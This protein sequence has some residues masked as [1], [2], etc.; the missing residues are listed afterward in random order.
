LAAP[1]GTYSLGA[2]YQIVNATGSY[3]ATWGGAG[4]PQVATILLALKASG[5][6]GSI[7][8]S[9]GASQS[10][11]VNTAFTN[12]LQA[13]VTDSGGHPVNGAV[14]TFSAPTT[15]AS[16]TFAGSSSATAV[17]NSSGIATSPTLTAN[18][19][20]GSYTITATTPAV[21]GAASFALSN[22]AGLPAGITATA[23]SGQSA[24][25][26][27]AFTALQATVKDANN[28]PV[29]GVSV[30]FTAP[31]SGASGAFGG[32]ATAIA[33]T[34]SSGV[35]TA[36][37][38][39]ANGQT[40]SYSVTANVT[41]TSLAAGF[42][43]TNTAAA[44]SG[45]LQGSGTSATTAVN[46]TSEGSTDWVHWGETPLNRKAGVTARLSTYTQ[47][48][49]GTVFAYN[50]DPRPVTW[51]DGTPAASS[52]GNANNGIYISGPGQGFSF[53]APA[54]QTTR[55]LVVHIG[56][57]NSGGTLT[58]HLS[59]G[60]ALDF[61]DTTASASGQYDRNYT[62]TYSASAAGKILTVT[63]QM[64]SGLSYGNVT[65]NAAA[66]H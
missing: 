37:A 64:T 12:A 59:D 24:A 45:S 32:S 6:A 58:A 18:A 31:A 66:L 15:G 10:A 35:A 5:G 63:W 56:G 1:A 8:A 21:A 9:A 38:L 51:S 43:L 3:A 53:T 50:N 27:T 42:S 22:T 28:N 29:N 46:L 16:A 52:A 39:T 44:S 48:G 61:T 2:A 54:D 57:W 23:G 65:L 25:V 14:V 41:G 7:S 36:P 11:V 30:T 49:A 19:Q 47:V 55:T 62:L 34:N 40:G 13:T 33:T 60:S 4:T 20:A 17:T 26:N